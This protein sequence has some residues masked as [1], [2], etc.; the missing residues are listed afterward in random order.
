MIRSSRPTRRWMRLFRDKRGSAAVEM[1]L[2]FP[3]FGY[4]VLNIMDYGV[5]ASAQTQAE[6]AAEAAVGAARN[7]CNSA[8]L[9]PATGSLARCGSTLTSQMTAAAQAT[10][11]G[12]AVTIGTPTEG[13]YCANAGGTL[14]SVAAINVTPPAT[15]AQVVSGSTSAPGDYISVTASYTYTPSAP[16]M[17][18]AALLP[19]TIQQTAWMRLL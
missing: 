6:S 4:V 17:A 1:A 12:T 5:Y 10:T 8:A 11:L 18:I 16:G 7:L 13:Y 14:V 2:C 19:T 15:C 9:L 3:I